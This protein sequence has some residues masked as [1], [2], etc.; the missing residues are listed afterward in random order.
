ML[1]APFL[2]IFV[3]LQSQEPPAKPPLDKVLAKVNGVPLTAAIVEPYLWDWRVGEVVDDLVLLQVAEQAAKKSNVT[4][5][6]EE[7][8]ARVKKE[9]AQLQAG[10]YDAQKLKDQGFPMSRIAIKIRTALLLERLTLIHFKPEDW[11]Q[12]G[13]M[14]F[15]ADAGSLLAWGKVSHQANETYT[16]LKKGVLWDQLK[17]QDA[18]ADHWVQLTTL[19]VDLSAKVKT[20][21]PGTVFPPRQNGQAIEITRLTAW[22]GHLSAPALEEL[23]SFYVQQ[24]RNA[25]LTKLR[26]EAKIEKS[27]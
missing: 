26:E 11:A 13:T 20:A 1:I 22:G 8:D 9:L 6:P 14:D 17:P 25:V 21:A 18:A 7:L 16:R 23:K 10:N 2:A 12:V 19:S 4:V 24:N 27:L 5:T 3:A 15:K